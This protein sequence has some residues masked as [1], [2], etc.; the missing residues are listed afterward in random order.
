MPL[1][2]LLSGLAVILVVLLGYMLPVV[3]AVPTCQYDYD[4]DGDIDGNDLQLFCT[5]K[6]KKVRY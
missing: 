1:R 2:R 3:W 4:G 5:I 6:G